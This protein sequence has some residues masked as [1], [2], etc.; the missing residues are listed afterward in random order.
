MAQV[1][2]APG[3]IAVGEMVLGD[4]FEGDGFVVGF[5]QFAVHAQGLAV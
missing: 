2:G 3:G 5:V 1:C 4:A